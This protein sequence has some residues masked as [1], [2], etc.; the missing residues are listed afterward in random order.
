LAEET[1]IEPEK[2][3]AG[4]EETEKKPEEGVEIVE[5]KVYS[6][7]LR[8]VWIAPQGVRAPRAVRL[9]KSFIGRH[10]KVEDVK[11]SAEVNEKI[12]SRGI[13]KPPRNLR[14]RAVKDKEGK[15]IVHLAEGD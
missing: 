4:K 2:E 6:I 3:K 9:I 1:E 15:V 8:K 5:E 13:R 14:V 10:M 12:W 7:P 11:I